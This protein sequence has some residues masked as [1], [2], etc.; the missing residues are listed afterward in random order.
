MAYNYK[1]GRFTP[2]HPEKYLGDVTRITYRSSYEL[3]VNQFFDNNPRVL[4]W[5]SEEVA[6]PYFNPVKK[7]PARYFPDYYVEYV[8][9]DGEIIKE[10]VEV[11]P[12][13]QTKQS[14]S[15][16]PRTKLL[17]DLTMAVNIAKWQA[18]ELWCNERGIKFR[19]ITERS[20][21]K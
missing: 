3:E 14:H 19:V 17:E 9:K 10:I 6:I 1:Q 15:R 5:A 2:K 12:L 16:N 20:I 8:T 11:K 7:R 4:K 13:Q 18:C 21:F